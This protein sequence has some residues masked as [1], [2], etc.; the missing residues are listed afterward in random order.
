MNFLKSFSKD[1]VN[2]M[3]FMPPNPITYDASMRNLFWIPE[4]KTRPSIPCVIF[5]PPTEVTF[6]YLMIYC[7]GNAMD[8]GQC[9][10]FL[11]ELAL[12]LGIYCVGFDYTGY[13]LTRERGEHPTEYAASRDGFAVYDYFVEEL[14]WPADRVI[15]FG[16]SIGTGIATS[17]AAEA[18]KRGDSTMALFLQSGYT[19]IRDVAMAFVGFPGMFIINRFNNQQRLKGL[20]LPVLF[21]HGD[22][23][24]VIPYEMSQ[25]MA[26]EY[27]GHDITAFHTA[28]GKGHN[29]MSTAI[30]LAIPFSE[31]IS[32]IEQ[33]RADTGIAIRGAP[34]N[35]DVLGRGDKLE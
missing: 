14:N 6:P 1:P 10:Y 5:H 26:A 24:E 2:W 34:E 18:Q 17:I 29:N 19:S 4:K 22:Q 21:A 7:H 35:F 27:K 12:H 3:M 28:N 25:I 15:I 20:K 33:H 11:Q 30:D 9:D 8:L 16:Q 23:D 32:R 31:M 13:G